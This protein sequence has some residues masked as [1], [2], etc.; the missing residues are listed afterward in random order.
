MSFSERLKSDINCQGDVQ[1]RQKK[2]KEK[3]MQGDWRK[4]EK[5]IDDD[6]Q[7]GKKE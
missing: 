2:E 7:G 4:N 1:M 6:K 3:K 5:M